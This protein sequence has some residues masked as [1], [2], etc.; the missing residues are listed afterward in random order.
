MAPNEPVR[1]ASPAT[2]WATPFQMLARAAETQQ[3]V[4]DEWRRHWLSMAGA[5]AVFKTR[6]Q[7]SGRISIPDAEREAIG[8]D[9]GDLVQVVVIPLGRHRNQVNHH[10]EPHDED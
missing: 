4:A 7:K 9:E 10:A 5:N 6:V 1:G 2:L 3:Q 8:L